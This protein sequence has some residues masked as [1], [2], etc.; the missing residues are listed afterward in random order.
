[1]CN[2]GAPNDYSCKPLLSLDSYPGAEHHE[3]AWMWQR[4][5][6]PA[7]LLQ[8]WTL[9]NGPHLTKVCLLCHAQ[10]QP[11][12]SFAVPVL[13]QTRLSNVACPGAVCVRL[14]VLLNGKRTEIL[15]ARS[16]SAV[17]WLSHLRVNLPF[18]FLHVRKA[19][20]RAFTAVPTGET[21][22]GGDSCSSHHAE[23]LLLVLRAACLW[24]QPSPP[25]KP[26]KAQRS[27]PLPGPMARALQG[28]HLSLDLSL[29]GGRLKPASFPSRW[30]TESFWRRTWQ[31]VFS[32]G[33]DLLMRLWNHPQ[34]GG[35]S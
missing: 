12:C 5:L 2:L 14:S 6:V 31:L 23:Q 7:L 32:S 33:A 34:E 21:C 35:L 18:G 13:E 15:E 16:Q 9:M 28:T 24:R 10:D 11:G 29:A 4:F 22:P 27:H 25:S 17:Q 3:G 19:E 8:Q 1:M 20:N 26:G 30:L